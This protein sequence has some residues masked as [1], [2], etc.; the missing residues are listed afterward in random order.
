MG[1]SWLNYL[2]RW[3]IFLLN[4]VQLVGSV[5]LGRV[6]V[7]KG[8]QDIRIYIYIN[9]NISKFIYI[10]I[11]KNHSTNK[12]NLFNCDK[13][14]NIFLQLYIVVHYYSFST[15]SY[16]STFFLYIYFIFK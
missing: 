12:N 11:P 16:H 1:L 3:V 6:R 14:S 4:F 5:T 7:W 15:N 10:Y 9:V 2:P 13:D 8:A